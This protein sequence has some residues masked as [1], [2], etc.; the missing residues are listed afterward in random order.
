LEKLQGTLDIEYYR[1]RKTKRSLKY[2]LQRRTLEVIQ[3]IKKYHPLG[4]DS[5]L[6]IGTADGL[7]LSKIKD[8]FPETSCIGLEYSEDLI[9]ANE[10]E[11]IEIIQGDARYL[12]F[13]DKSFSIAIATAVIE[14]LQNPVRMLTEAYR[15]LLGGG[16][17]N[18]YHPRS[19]L[20]TFGYGS[21]AS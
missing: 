17:L 12:P 21:W 1:G 18:T 3:A 16:V 6:D 19:F 11:K 2:R 10:D 15:I 13:D 20:G 8:E 9:V 14:H 7:M 4:I 5:I